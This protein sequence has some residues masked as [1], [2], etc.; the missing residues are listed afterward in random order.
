MSAALVA[1]DLVLAPAWLLALGWLWLA[2]RT[3]R[4]M[5]QLPN[6][7][8]ID[9]QALPPLPDGD[10]PHLT[11]LLPACNEE[12][13]IRATLD[14]LLASEGLRPAPPTFRQ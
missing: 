5:R 2:V 12:P 1:R 9:P 13:V 3:L 7:T 10:E 6:L 14:S 8:R 11:V 4:G